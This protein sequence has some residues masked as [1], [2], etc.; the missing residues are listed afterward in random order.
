MMPKLTSSVRP[1]RPNTAIMT[2]VV[3]MVGVSED[4]RR[5][6]RAVEGREEAVAVDTSGNCK[7][8]HPPIYDFANTFYNVLKKCLYDFYQLLFSF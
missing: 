3:K 4:A 6:R 7:E 1:S 2:R 5:L 8:N